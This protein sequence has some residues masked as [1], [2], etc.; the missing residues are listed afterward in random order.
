MTFAAAMNHE[1]LELKPVAASAGLRL[2]ATALKDDHHVAFSLLVCRDHLLPFYNRLGWLSFRR[3]PV[4]GAGRGPRGVHD[5]LPNGAVR[6]ARS[7]T[8]RIVDLNGPPW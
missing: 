8:G 6:A 4:R 5:Q 3:P 2:A 1:R 7:P